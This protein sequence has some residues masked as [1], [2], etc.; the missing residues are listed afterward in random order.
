MIK[1]ICGGATVDD[2]AKLQN[3]RGGEPILNAADK[4]KF[5]DTLKAEILADFSSTAIMNPGSKFPLTAESA[6]DYYVRLSVD[7]AP[8]GILASAIQKSGL[9]IPNHAFGQKIR[10]TIFGDGRVEN[11]DGQH[12][13]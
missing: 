2:I 6:A 1:L 4:V 8:E 13:E 3:G 7:Y 9:N 5:K 12:L 10:T 11:Q